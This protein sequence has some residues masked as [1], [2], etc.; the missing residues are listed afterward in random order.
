MENNRMIQT[1]KNT[2]K[3]NYN[4]LNKHLDNRVQRNVILKPYTSFKI[5]GPASFFLEAKTPSEIIKAVNLAREI[6]LKYFVLGGGSNILFDDLGFNGL[7]IRD[8][9]DKFRINGNV[10][11]ALS[12]TTID[13]L[14]DA[15]VEQGLS[16][17]EYAA[18]IKGTIGGSVYGNAG[19]FG[20]AINEILDKAVIY[21]T[22]DK[23]EIVDNKYFEFS[24]RKSRISIS[25]DV[26]ISVKLVL[27]RGDS[28][29]LA[30]IV[31]ERRQFR[32]DRHPVDM[33]SAGSVFKNLR[34]LENPKDVTPAGKLLEEAG[35]RGLAVGDAAV[36]EKHCNIV[37]NK[38]NAKSEDVK[39]VIQIM[40]NAVFDKF[41]IDLEREIIYIDP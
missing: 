27:N 31:K 20:H 34:S 14:V 1:N 24:Y 35:V 30:E 26:L 17:M 21:T 38:G 5:G 23:I 41:A 4:F 7:V 37:V 36:F 11:G 12:G 28:K 19:A 3:A 33:G 6:K 2:H 8:L 39:K 10:V 25:N 18:G 9:T 29:K 15:T 22:D 13:K 32:K 40:K 16:G